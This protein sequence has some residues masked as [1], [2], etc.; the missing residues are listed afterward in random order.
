MDKKEWL[1]S[2]KFFLFSISAGV[3]QMGSFALLNELTGLVEWAS[4]LISLVLSVIW[5]FT[6]NRKFTFKSTGNITWAMLLVAGYYCVFTPLSTWLEYYLVDTLVWNEYIVTL[7]N[8]VL[9]LVTE[10]LFQRFVVYRNSVDNAEAK[11]K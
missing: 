9:N 6:F 2:L 8:M 3:I 4:Y 7:I 5:N 10:F 11:V 1:R